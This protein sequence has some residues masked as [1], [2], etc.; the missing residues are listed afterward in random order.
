MPDTLRSADAQ[1]VRA[2][3]VGHISRNRTL[4]DPVTTLGSRQGK[5]IIAI[6]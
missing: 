2:F 6:L 3:T 4:F 5:M 1:G